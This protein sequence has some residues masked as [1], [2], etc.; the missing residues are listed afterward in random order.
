MCLQSTLGLCGPALMSSIQGGCG[1]DVFARVKWTVAL[2]WLHQT[3]SLSTMSKLVQQRANTEVRT[4][5]QQSTPGVDRILS[6]LSIK[7][8]I[9]RPLLQP[10]IISNSFNRSSISKVLSFAT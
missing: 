4:A 10:L 6:A 3:W 9:P 2:H 8:Q 1:A 7:E 5:S